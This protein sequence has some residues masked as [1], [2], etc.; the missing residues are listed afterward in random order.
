MEFRPGTV[1]RKVYDHVVTGNE[2]RLPADLDGWHVLDI[3]AHI[4]SFAVACLNRNCRDILAVEADPDNYRMLVKN[5]AH[6]PSV[7]TIQAAAW[8]VKTALSFTPSTAQFNTG[9]AGVGDGPLRVDTIA[10]AQLV[11][12]IVAGDDRLLLKLDCEGSEWPIL[13]T[14]QELRRFKRII[15]EYH[16]DRGNGYPSTIQDLRALL[17]TQGFEV[18]IEDRQPYGHFWATRK[19]LLPAA[20]NSP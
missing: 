12:D 14:S 16:L 1:D 4:G 7:R 9:G 13:H 18:E 6:K 15:G 3:G 8:P 10:F 5:V 19:D 17:E 20:T 2:Y 11:K